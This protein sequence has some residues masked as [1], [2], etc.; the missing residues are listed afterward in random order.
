[1]HCCRTHREVLELSH[2]INIELEF[3]VV[4]VESHSQHTLVVLTHLVILHEVMFN[5]TF[6]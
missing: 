5:I 6:K 2:F 1:M 4:V 3:G